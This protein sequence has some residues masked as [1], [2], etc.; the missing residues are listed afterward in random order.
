MI[1]IMITVGHLF[2]LVVVLLDGVFKALFPVLSLHAVVVIVAAAVA[3]ATVI[4]VAVR[5]VQI[6]AG[7]LR[8]VHTVTAAHHLN[9]LTY[10]GK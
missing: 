8:V 4:V 3:A 7:Q 6:H 10:L 9:E 2:I 5:V 1:T